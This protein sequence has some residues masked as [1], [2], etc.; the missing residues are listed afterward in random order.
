MSTSSSDKGPANNPATR[1]LFGLLSNGQPLDIPIIGLCG[2]YGSGKTLA[3]LTLCP[4]E[5]IEIGVEDSGVTYNLP[6]K[7]RFS[8]Y[9]EVTGKSGVTPK[10]VEC[11]EWFAGILE[12]IAKDELKCRVLFVDPITDIQGGLVDWVRDHAADFKKS[13]AQYDKASGLL[14]ADVKSHAKILLGRVSSKCTLIFTAH[15]GSVWSGGAPVTGKQKAKGIDTFKELASLYV[16]LTREV[17]PKTGL[18]PEQPIGHICPPHGKS[19]LAHMVQ[20]AETGDWESKAILPPRIDPF[21]WQ[22]LRSYVQTPPNYA[23]LKASEK[24]E[25]EKLSDDDKL[26]LAAET[27]RTEL[28]AAQLRA[29]LAEKAEAAAARAGRTAV[30][31]TVA[32]ATGAAPTGTATTA[33]KTEA[34]AK[35]PVAD[36]PKQEA[37]KQEAP[38]EQPAKTETAATTAPVAESAEPLIRFPETLPDWNRETCMSIVKEQIVEAKMTDE[39]ATSAAKKRGA[40]SIDELTDEKLEDLRRALWTV[41]TKREMEK[42][43]KAKK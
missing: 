15:M 6:L 12:K 39:L 5:T 41:L 24:A 4:E 19:R 20:N 21:T 7:K 3:G 11:W 31:S 2:G 40:N 33:A 28:E 25:V 42:R 30:S 36:K 1:P 9:K 18:Q 14:W 16:F 22:K 8:M 38:K 43:E 32:R 10:P 17:D 13:Q 34:P 26:L 37:L 35:P 27:A 23:K 29:E